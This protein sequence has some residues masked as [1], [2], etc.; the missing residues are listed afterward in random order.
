MNAPRSISISL[1]VH[2]ALRMATGLVTIA[3]P[4]IVGFDVAATLT[5]PS[6]GSAQTSPIDPYRSTP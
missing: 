3:A 4:L 5:T 6:A 2:A 1:P